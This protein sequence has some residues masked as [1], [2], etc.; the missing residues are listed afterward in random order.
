MKTEGSNLTFHIDEATDHLRKDILFLAIDTTLRHIENVLRK[1]MLRAIK[2]DIREYRCDHEHTNKKSTPKKKKDVLKEPR[3][4][5]NNNAAERFSSAI[6]KAK[7]E[8]ASVGSGALSTALKS[9]K[10]ELKAALTLKTSKTIKKRSEVERALKDVYEYLSER[11]F[12][13]E[14]NKAATKPVAE[15]LIPDKINLAEIK[16]KMAEKRAFRVRT[17]MESA[18]QEIDMTKYDVA[19][20]SERLRIAKMYEGSTHRSAENVVMEDGFLSF[21][22]HV[23]AMRLSE[24]F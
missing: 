11:F 2:V 20:T 21:K 13:Y 4:L 8:H 19:V 7:I 15:Q 5:A 18:I 12:A 10:L 3:F 17:R 23:L 14:T 6:V 9:K 22:E 24:F 1:S 16:L